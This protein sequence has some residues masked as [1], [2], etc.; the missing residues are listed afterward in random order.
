MYIY[1]EE[2][3]IKSDMINPPTL[4]RVIQSSWAEV[5]HYT[6]IRRI[7]EIKGN[8]FAVEDCGYLPIYFI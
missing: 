1:I 8:Y 3:K 4:R 7:L 2:G 5:K 6:E